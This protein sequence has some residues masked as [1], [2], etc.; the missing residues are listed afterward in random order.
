MFFMPPYVVCSGDKGQMTPGSRAIA[1][2]H[3]TEKTFQ[4]GK[5]FPRAFPESQCTKCCDQP[6][7]GSFLLQNFYFFYLKYLN[8]LLTL[9]TKFRMSVV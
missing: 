1:G 5:Y 7:L 8:F 3:G 6:R 9:Y 4:L 2:H